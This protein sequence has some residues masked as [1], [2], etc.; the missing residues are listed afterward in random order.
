MAE[1][2]A[3][4]DTSDKHLIYKIYNSNMTGQG[5][6]YVFK[7][8]KKMAQLAINMDQKQL[9][10]CPLMEEPAYF[11]GMHK[12]CQGWKTLTLWLYHPASCHLY[13]IAMMEVKAE[14]SVNC[15]KFRK[16]FNEMLQEL[17]NDENYYFNPKRFI[18]DEAGANHNGIAAIYGEQGS[19][20]SSTCQFHF[21][22][23]L[24]AMLAKFPTTILEQRN[25]FEMLMTCL[26][27]VPVL[28]EYHEII[29]RI[30]AICALVPAVE[31]QVKWWLARHYN[32]F[33]L[34]RG[35]CLTSLNMAEIGHSTLKK[36]KP[37]ALVDAAWE[38][39]CTAIMQ[40]QEHTAFLEG[41]CRS[42]GKG[43]TATEIGEHAKRD[44]MGRSREYQQ[45]FREGR[46]SIIEEEEGNF[47]PSKRAKHR[48]AEQ[49]GDDVQGREV[50]LQQMTTSVQGG[51]IQT[52]QNNTENGNG[53]VTIR[54]IEEGNQ[55]GTTSTT[56]R[57][58]LATLN[59][60][61]RDNPPL[62]CFLAGHNIRQCYGCKNKFGNSMQT[63][64]NDIIIKMQVVRDR[65]LNNTWVPG[66][67]RSWG[68]FHPNINCLKLEKSI[69]EVED[70]YSH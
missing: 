46:T 27:T 7:L 36:K 21:K 28:A 64:P 22:K 38:D 52:T 53:Q 9:T 63:P 20:K 43:P 24:E 47:I 1:L 13:K 50:P 31:G 56:P 69:L 18:T 57:R 32:L 49:V 17:R 54:R 29:S 12:H 59:M 51:N 45:A 61:N 4:T 65:L 15:A 37:L 42:S 60:Q 62:L 66:W 19:N 33:P 23:Q 10:K 2:K 6:S 3:I 5:N 25:E 68:Y 44:Q 40:E 16:V 35:Y 58:P 67:K 34:F 41:R 8:S 48:P 30:K 70:I 26:L 14:D 55:V 11:D 39:V